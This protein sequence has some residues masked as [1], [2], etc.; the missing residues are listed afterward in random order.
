MKIC[1][2]TKY[3]NEL[4]D[5]LTRVK[6]CCPYY[7]EGFITLGTILIP[8]MMIVGVQNIPF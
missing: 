3:I 4:I 8:G 1:N 6:Q 2:D 5:N 7:A